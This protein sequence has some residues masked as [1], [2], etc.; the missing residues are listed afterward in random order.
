MR[1]RSDA[2][3]NAA[4]ENPGSMI[5]WL[6]EPFPDDCLRDVRR[7][8][9]LRAVEAAVSECATV[10]KAEWIDATRMRLAV[11]YREVDRSRLYATVL[12]VA[13]SLSCNHFWVGFTLGQKVPL[14]PGEEA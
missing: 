9:A 2:P 3:G 7:Y 13:K 4:F 11:E 8:W 12:G 10:A 1:A 6:A 5:L 14:G